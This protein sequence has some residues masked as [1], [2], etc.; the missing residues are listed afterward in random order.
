MSWFGNHLHILFLNIFFFKKTLT[1]APSLWYLAGLFKKSTNSITSCLASL[2]P[3]T[4][5]NFTP[6]PDPG[7]NG[8]IIVKRVGIRC[9]NW[10][11]PAKV[12]SLVWSKEIE[13]EETYRQLFHSYRIW[14][15]FRGGWSKKGGYQ[16]EDD[17]K[18]NEILHLFT[19]LPLVDNG[20]S[21]V[22]ADTQTHF[23]LSKTRFELLHA[24]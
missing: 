17:E 6:R 21:L 19:G 9:W 14:E 2:A 23:C 24:H 3:A 22:W 12:L 16:A 1:F 4:S 7:S 5:E 8:S 20:H 11:P 13:L 15:D 10:T 18:S